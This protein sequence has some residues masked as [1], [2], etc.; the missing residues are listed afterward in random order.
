[1]PPPRSSAFALPRPRA[2]FTVFGL[3]VIVTALSIAVAIAVPALQRA[4]ANSRV[5]AVA[6]DLREFSAGLQRYAGEQG[7]WPSESDAGVLPP[8]AGPYV[9][10]AFTRVTP[11]GGKYNWENNQ[12]Q[13]FGSRPRAA[14]AISSTAGAPLS[15]TGE[16]VS[17]LYALDL[18]FDNEVGGW[19]TGHFRLNADLLPLFVIEP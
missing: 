9:G 12:V 16:T 3:M 13:L 7:S 4:Q 1:M 5:A 10:A 6:H 18:E 15:P 17:M 2:G 19:A 14:I 8:G 11:I